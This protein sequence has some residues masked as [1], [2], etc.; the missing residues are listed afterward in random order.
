[1]NNNNTVETDKVGLNN[2]ARYFSVRQYIGIIQ[3]IGLPLKRTVKAHQCPLQMLHHDI[4][5]FN[6]DLGISDDRSS[7][8]G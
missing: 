7:T 8:I 2:R 3:I 6:F 4:C 1:M 5:P